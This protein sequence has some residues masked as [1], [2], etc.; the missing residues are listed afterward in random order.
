MKLR[1]V[2]VVID[3]GHIIIGNDT[4][5]RCASADVIEKAT[6]KIEGDVVHVGMNG[7]M[8]LIRG[9]MK[10]VVGWRIRWL[11]LLVLS[12]RRHFG[13][14]SSVGKRRSG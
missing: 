14:R 7:N 11:M 1:N 8:N 9:M 13:V 10:V 12:R 3:D 4:G 2:F 5:F 6:V